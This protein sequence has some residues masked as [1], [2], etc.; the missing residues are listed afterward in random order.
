MKEGVLLDRARWQ[1]VVT[2]LLLT[3]VNKTTLVPPLLT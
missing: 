1:V 2:S 3:V